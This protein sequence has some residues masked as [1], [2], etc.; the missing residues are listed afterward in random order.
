MHAKGSQVLEAAQFLSI[1]MMAA[2]YL[3]QALQPH[4]HSQD[5]NTAFFCKLVVVG[6]FVQASV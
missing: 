2:G 4:E 3:K 1:S 5:E 6:S